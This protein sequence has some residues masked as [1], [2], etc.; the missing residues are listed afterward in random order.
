MAYQI[1]MI[2][3]YVSI[4]LLATESIYVFVN[5]KT[6][7]QTYLFLYCF[8]T[9]INNISY[10]I[11]MTAQTSREALIG[12]QMCYVGKIWI[13][14]SF[15]AMLNEIC[16]IKFPKLIYQI[17]IGINVM[18]LGMM[19]TCDKH[20]LYYTADREFV[21][22]GLFPHNVYGH[23]WIYYA[24]MVV[25]LGYIVYSVV[26]LVRQ[27]IVDKDKVRRSTYKYLIP[28]VIAMTL[29]YVAYMTRITNGYDS[30]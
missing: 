11:V 3:Q 16:E 25:V 15:V 30:E 13:P 2:I 20:Y 5:M 18:I 12:A 19:L 14:L 27:C 10:M 26:L 24:Y 23:T 17:A 21:Q 9:L 6:K 29:G 8:S 1:I 4:A 22:T 7:G 28:A